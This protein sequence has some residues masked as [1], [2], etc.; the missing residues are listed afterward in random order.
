[1]RKTPL[2]GAA[3]GLRRRLAA[4]RDRA[5]IAASPL[6]D[7][8]WYARTYPEVGTA[9]PLGHYLETGAAAGLRPS[10]WFDAAWYA[11]TYSDVAGVNPLAHYIA[12]GAAEGR[13]PNPFFA[14]R[15]YLRN[16]PA[17]GAAT[18]PLDHYVTEGARAL[19]DPSPGFDAAWYAECHPPAA[20]D[21][22]AHF[23]LVGRGAGLSPSPY[24]RE[25]TGHP[26]SAARIETVKAL[27]PLAGEVVALFVA[28]APE[29]RLKPNVA[30]YLAALD[31]AGVRVVLVV[32]TDRPFS[33]EAAVEGRLAGL[34]VRDN[35]GY[36]F[37][38]WAHAMR[39]ERPRQPRRCGRRHREPGT[40]LAPAELLPRLQ[41]PG[42][43]LGRPAGLLQPGPRSG[44]Q[45][46]GDRR[47]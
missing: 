2:G 45:G 29:G 7:A 32:A 13:D 4:R 46:R 6:F 42:G 9:D 17:A 15:W 40:G 37:A 19:R 5:L 8:D 3:T 10:A 26:V 30:P 34:L 11:E 31:A 22:L 47:L 28:H 25:P 39:C 18:T 14:T 41:A 38:A 1:M 35:Q 23:L 12:F 24:R 16:N 36:D 21:P 44:G 33:V 20:A 43:L 27:Q